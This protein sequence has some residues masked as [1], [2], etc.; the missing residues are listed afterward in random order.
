MSW[1]MYAI[2]AIAVVGFSDL[3]RKMASNLHDPFLSNLVFQ[4]GS[5]VMTVVMYL[6]F[7][8]KFVWNPRDMTIA[9]AGGMLVSV[10]T[11]LSFKTLELGPGLSVVM[12]VL[13]IGGVLATAIIGVLLLHEKMNIQVL[14]GLLFSFLGIYLLFSS[15]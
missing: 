2:I 11:M 14:S 3:S 8:R 6:L 13:R 12:P 1:V 5:I 9:F 15:K 7:S 10:F 4:T